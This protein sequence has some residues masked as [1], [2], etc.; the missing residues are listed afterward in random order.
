MDRITEM[1]DQLS[2]LDDAQV[3]ELQ[4]AIISEFETVETEE[5]SSQTVDAMTS[6]ADMLDTV[7]G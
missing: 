4:N 6:L 2:E 5:P 7:R 1:L 3:D